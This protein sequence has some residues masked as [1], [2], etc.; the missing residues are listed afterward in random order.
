MEK[1]YILKGIARGTTKKGNDYSILNLESEFDDYNKNKGAIGLSCD[2][3]YCKG[4]VDSALLGKKVILI[5]GCG[6]DDKAYV[7]NVVLAR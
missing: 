5:Y 4:K 1:D 6:F 3:K 7:Q 2:S